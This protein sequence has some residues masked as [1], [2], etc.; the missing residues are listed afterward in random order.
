MAKNKACNFTGSVM[1]QN[2]KLILV[3]LIGLVTSA[4]GGG[5]RSGSTTL[6]VPLSVTSA[7]I[8]SITAAALKVTSGSTF[9]I[10]N[11]TNYAIA[12]LDSLNTVSNSSPLCITTPT[13]AMV[14]DTAFQPGTITFFNCITQSGKTINGTVSLNNLRFETPGFGLPDTL[15]A[16]LTFNNLAITSSS[17]TVTVTGGY[18]LTTTGTNL[19]FPLTNATTTAKN[20]NLTFSNNGTVIQTEVI[21]NINFQTD[22]FG[23]S[24]STHPHSFTLSSTFVGGAFTYTTLAPFLN[25]SGSLHPFDGMALIKGANLTQLRITVKAD[26]KASSTPNQV[27][28]EFSTDGGNLYATSIPY[29]WAELDPP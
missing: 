17:P 22:L 9:D 8:Q 29:T 10:F 19:V 26:E 18:D 14:V 25:H 16:T 4:C 23:G 11:P 2:L 13:T 6:S 15:S 12:I 7:N 28:V 21:S 1:M 27:E 24:S 20:G 3:I 5:E